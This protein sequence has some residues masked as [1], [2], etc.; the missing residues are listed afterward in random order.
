MIP[1]KE[2]RL[3]VQSNLDALTP[4][5]STISAFIGNQLSD[6]EKNRVILAVDEA[7]SNIIIHGY[8]GSPEGEIELIMQETPE[9]FKFILCDAAEPY[10]PL[11]VPDPDLDAYHEEGRDGGL[12]VNIYRRILKVVYEKAEE[13]GNRLIMIR[14]KGDDK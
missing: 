14:E 13:G 6:I 2:T 3:R 9:Q 1:Q 12:G 11:T 4:L 10:N 8:K 7:V 5:R